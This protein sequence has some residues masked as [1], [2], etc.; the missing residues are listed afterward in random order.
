MPVQIKRRSAPC[1]TSEFYDCETEW[2][3]PPRHVCRCTADCG[4]I[5]GHSYMAYGPLLNGATCVV[6]E[7]IPTHPDAGRSWEIVDK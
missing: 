4:W 2:S 7:G 3:K 5:T 1:T 6:F